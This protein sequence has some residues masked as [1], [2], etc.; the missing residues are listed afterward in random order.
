[1][2]SSLAGEYQHFEGT[3]VITYKTT[4]LM[5]MVMIMSMG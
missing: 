1:M 2:A 4:A 5:M 3:L